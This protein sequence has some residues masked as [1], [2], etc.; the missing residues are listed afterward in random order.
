MSE[1][2]PKPRRFV[3]APDAVILVKL[4]LAEA[5]NGGDI[6]TFA[7][8]SEALGRKVNGGSPIV[9]AAKRH[10]ESQYEWEFANIRGEGYEHLTTH[11]ILD[12]AIPRNRKSLARKAR[13]NFRTTTRVDDT[14]LSP[15]ERTRFYSEQAYAGTLAQVTRPAAFRKVEARVREVKA[16]IP[17]AETLRLFRE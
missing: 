15:E 5:P 16:S 17:V 8:M 6:L 3:L 10:L 7:R 14:E 2:D 12:R 11:G 1:I 4:W 13:R 9:Q